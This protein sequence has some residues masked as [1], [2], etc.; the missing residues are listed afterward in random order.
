MRDRDQ[1][2][3]RGFV[4]SRIMDLV[5]LFVLIL[6]GIGAWN[7]LS[8]LVNGDF[9]LAFFMLW[10]MAAG[11]AW[12]W[13]REHKRVLRIPAGLVVFL[14]L[15]A[16]LLPLSWWSGSKLVVAVEAAVL[17]ALVHYFGGKWSQRL[18]TRLAPGSASPWWLDQSVNLV[19]DL[20]RCVAYSA[21]AFFLV[22][23]PSMLLIFFMPLEE[24]HWGALALSFAATAWYLIKVRKT[25]G[26]FLRVPLGLWA[27]VPAAALLKILQPQLA[28]PLEVGSFELITYAAYWPVVAALF[29]ELVLVGTR[30][31]VSPAP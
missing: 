15:G 26:L 6:I 11:T 23:V 18:A 4:H 30:G 8:T 12:W 29:V 14:V 21:L 2:R 10:L 3:Q 1:R 22:V 27:F 20:A 5:F 17:A 9:T 28:G 16:V 31:A 25:R 19:D 7:W 13:S 24:V